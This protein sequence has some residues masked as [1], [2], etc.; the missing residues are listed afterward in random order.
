MPVNA[1]VSGTL[2]LAALMDESSC[3]LL[4]DNAD[5]QARDVPVHE[6]WRLFRNIGD[7]VVLT[8]V[9]RPDVR[10]T[11]ARESD[12][13]QAVRLVL[14]SLDRGL[15]V[16]VRQMNIEALAAFL[17]E[18]ETCG[19]VRGVFFCQP[20]ADGADVEGAIEYCRELNCGECLAFFGDMLSYQ[21]IIKI[22]W[23]AWLEVPDDLFGDAE[24]R[25]RF[26]ATMIR[27][28]RFWHACR[29]CKS[30]PSVGK[31]LLAYRLEPSPEERSLHR[32]D[33][34][35]H[36]VG[37]L[38][39]RHKDRL[40]A[41]GEAPAV[42]DEPR[43]KRKKERDAKHAHRLQ[44]RR[45][46]IHSD[47]EA[48]TARV[49]RIQKLVRAGKLAPA[50]KYITDL[51]QD[52]LGQGVPEMACKSLCSAAATA[53]EI[54]AF[55]IAIRWYRQAKEV[56]PE[57][58]VAKSG[59]AE[60][61]RAMGRFDEALT[62]CQE[63]CKHHPEDVVAKNALAETFRSMGRFD[64]ALTAYQDACKHHPE[65]VVAKTGL[66][67]TFRSMGRFEEAL[68]AYQDACKHHPESVFAKTGLAETF[69][70]MGRFD[71]ALTAYQDACKQHPESVVAKT[72]LA[73]TFRSMGRF[74]E[75]LSAYQDACKRHPESVVAKSGLAE[76]FRSMGRFDE[77][78]SAYQDACKHHPESVVA[79]NGLAETFR[80]M[81]RFDEALSAYQDACKRHPESV[82]AK[83]GLAETFRSMGRF[84]EALSA[85]QDACKR[86]PESVVAK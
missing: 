28:K 52:Q 63:A 83:N 44:S 36:W 8:D 23:Q 49:E 24:E 64:E 72:G 2:E 47:Y 38:Q 27:G 53:V 29:E 9:E 75:A 18:G 61:F 42:I 5:D 40:S 6:V 35:T 67:E 54:C 19:R 3:Q 10:A 13:A 56:C 85:Y 69:R 73:E 81:G 7:V 1:L 22:A 58:V 79:K 80:S 21:D 37:L 39:P 30:S 43:S 77:A 34:I 26:L 11:L 46:G 76:T 16:G 4:S 57:D 31:V 45:R 25:Q 60:T 66:A 71:E 78:L 68:S 48:A 20:L 12:V 14:N 17:G 74:E 41:E 84:D 70:S 15:P 32:P 51:V 33:V 55:D 59:L 82:V 65:D 86:H 50:E 62:A